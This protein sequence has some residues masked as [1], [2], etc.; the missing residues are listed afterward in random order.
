[1]SKKLSNT[2]ERRVIE[3][4][5]G[6]NYTFPRLYQSLTVIN[7]SE[8]S[9]LSII[10][11]EHPDQIDYAIWGMLPQGYHDDWQ[12]FQNAFDTLSIDSKQL[13]SVPIYKESFLKR[14]CLII[15]TGFFSY[16]VHKGALYPYHIYKRKNNPFCIAGVYNILEDGFITCA[17]ITKEATG[18]LAEIQNVN[19]AMPVI[20]SE[21]N[22]DEWLH[23]TSGQEQL[24]QLM[25]NTSDFDL[26]ADPIARELFNHNISFESMLAPVAYNNIPG[27]YRH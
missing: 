11:A 14:R 21:S 8:E 24:L 27:Q 5:L 12:G 23:P 20:L 17:V 15:I 7:G 19:D 3:R 13:L 16:H 4:A 10:T 6:R 18:V 1:M 22:Y 26:N 2:A 9:L 25:D